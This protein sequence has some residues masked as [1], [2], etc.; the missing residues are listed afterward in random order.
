MPTKGRTTMI[1]LRYPARARIQALAEE[2]DRPVLS[3][4]GLLSRVP[5][6]YFRQLARRHKAEE[7]AEKEFEQ[8]QRSE[9]KAEGA[10]KGL[11]K[12]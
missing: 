9:R 10:K 12:A 4:I 7:R 2:F 8:A 3:V 6:S 5:P 1:H 11:D